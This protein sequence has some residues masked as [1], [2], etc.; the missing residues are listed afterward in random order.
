LVSFQEK[1]Y[2]SLLNPSTAKSEQPKL[3]DAA[4]VLQDVYPTGPR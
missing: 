3:G 1:N 2:L 4:S